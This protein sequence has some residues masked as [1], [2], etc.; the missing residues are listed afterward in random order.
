MVVPCCEA[1]KSLKNHKNWI[2]DT[3]I[4]C[5]KLPEL[6]KIEETTFVDPP[7]QPLPANPPILPLM[8]S[9]AKFF[10]WYLFISSFWPK[11]ISFQ[12]VKHI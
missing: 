12:L 1:L 7:C 11:T 8:L 5:P 6:K 9:K 2:E 3:R 4:R 10:V